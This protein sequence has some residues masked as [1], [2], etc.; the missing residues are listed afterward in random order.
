MVEAQDITALDM[1][2]TLMTGISVPMAHV[3]DVTAAEFP[4]A[5][6]VMPQP[7]RLVMRGTLALLVAHKIKTSQIYVINVVDKIIG[8]APVVHLPMLLTSIT[9]D[10]ELEKPTLL[11]DEFLMILLLRLLT[12]RL[13]LDMTRSETS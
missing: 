7:R 12:S 10:A 5:G 8:P 6:T 11:Q 1:K 13:P 4:V 3:A 2:L 9:L